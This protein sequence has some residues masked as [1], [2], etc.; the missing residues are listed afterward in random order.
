MSSKDATSE[1]VPFGRSRAL[2]RRLL[3]TAEA[4]HKKNVYSASFFAQRDISIVDQ[5]LRAFKLC[6][7][8]SQDDQIRPKKHIAIV[9]A[10][11]SGM[12]CAVALTMRHN[13]TVSVF[14]QEATLLKKFRAAAFRYIHPDLNSR[15][16]W[17]EHRYL[18]RRGK[19]RYP[20]LN[21]SA[22]FAPLVAEEVVRKFDHYR[23]VT[24]L[25]LH[26]GE[27]VLSVE[28]DGKRPVLSVL[29]ENR[30]E[31]RKLAVDMVIIATGFG[32]ERKSDDT[33]DVSYWHSG[34]PESYRPIKRPGKPKER[35][36]LSGN[37]DSGI[38]ELAHYLIQD[39]DHIEIFSFLPDASGF[40]RFEAPNDFE[41]LPHRIIEHEF[42]PSALDLPPPIIW[43]FQSR[44]KIYADRGH[45]FFYDSRVSNKYAAMIFNCMH[46]YLHAHQ[47]R[48]SIS[49][50]DLADMEEEV[51]DLLFEMASHEIGALMKTFTIS[52]ITHDAP[53]GR[54]TRRALKKR[55]HGEF[56]ITI[57]GQSPTIYSK[58][59]APQTWFLLRVL[60]VFGKGQF[61]YKFVPRLSNKEKSGEL[62][63]RKPAIDKSAFDRVVVRHG[64]SYTSLVEPKSRR[65]PNALIDDPILWW[66][67][68]GERKVSYHDELCR[69]FRTNR[70][71]RALERSGPL[72]DSSA[73]D[74]SRSKDSDLDGL[75]LD[76]CSSQNNVEAI[77]IYR[78]LKRSRGPKK[79]GLVRR[80]RRLA[81]PM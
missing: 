27:E 32:E 65:W 31:L 70:W 20:F 1:S 53:S 56:E 79:M 12:T 39:F 68:T 67:W 13:C 15:G 14:D 54:A 10:G 42:H 6:Y 34:N 57:T 28:I 76:A 43:Y 22:H 49:E 60:E 61:E 26:L 11:F 59:Q 3:V 45:R 36:L 8:L 30:I 75:L 64:P 48:D 35:I 50:D 4:A 7:A 52:S 78:Y 18:D 71:K 16:G 38:I 41:N 23:R 55:F 63:A 40:G 25:A 46:R 72:D 80:L 5:Q 37:G 77:R 29:S 74:N 62:V 17:H 9:G 81:D 24:N 47:P 21:W 66:N 19:T 44:E 73:E 69:Y 33:N 58:K 2:W 51:N